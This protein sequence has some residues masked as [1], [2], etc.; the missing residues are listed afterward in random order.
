M[1]RTGDSGGASPYIN[2]QQNFQDTL[3]LQERQELRSAR[4]NEKG[5]LQVEGKSGEEIAALTSFYNSTTV[6]IDLLRNPSLP[7]LETLMKPSGRVLLAQNDT[8]AFDGSYGSLQDTVAYVDPKEQQKKLLKEYSDYTN[9]ADKEALAVNTNKSTGLNPFKKNVTPVRSLTREEYV[10]TKRAIDNIAEQA[11]NSN[12]PNLKATS[13]R[14]QKWLREGWILA[15]T[16]LA[17]GVYA[18]TRRDGSSKPFMLPTTLG[19]N[20]CLDGNIYLNFDRGSFSQKS[21]EYQGSLKRIELF[22]KKLSNPNITPQQK[23]GYEKVLRDEEAYIKEFNRMKDINLEGVLVHE[24]EHS[25]QRYGDMKAKE[26][27][28]YDA[29]LHYLEVRLKNAGSP[30]EKKMIEDNI[31]MWK[32]LKQEKGL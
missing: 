23:A 19:E 29:Q 16:T 4:L 12:D 21:E 30:E 7:S 22:R 11:S 10:Q 1:I 18:E 28:A 27:P 6:N 8:V 24:I 5:L 15:D 20:T 3:S 26:G 14:L 2:S 25:N 32:L 13:E 31:K 17:N 9:K